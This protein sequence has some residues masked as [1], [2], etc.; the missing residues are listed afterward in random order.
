MQ[1]QVADPLVCINGVVFFKTHLY[2][3]GFCWYRDIILIII[4]YITIE[5][6]FKAL[7]DT[8]SELGFLLMLVTLVYNHVNISLGFKIQHD[9]QGANFSLDCPKGIPTTSVPSVCFHMPASCR[10]VQEK[11][12]LSCAS[13]ATLT[14]LWS[15]VDCTCWE[16]GSCW[17]ASGNHITVDRSSFG[18][19]TQPISKN[20]ELLKKIQWDIYTN[21]WQAVSA[22]FSLLTT[23]CCLV[24]LSFFSFLFSPHK[25]P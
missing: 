6:N 16:Q 9:W 13:P 10:Q 14:T 17:K 20:C 11:H 18:W 21:H 2:R 24:F 7:A 5:L 8:F 12:V 4:T 19:L 23:S 22:S 25:T 15:D 3:L 1:S